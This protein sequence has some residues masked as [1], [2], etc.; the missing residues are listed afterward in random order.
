MPGEPK[1]PGPRE[2]AELDDEV[3]VKFR[4]GEYGRVLVTGLTDLVKQYAPPGKHEHILGF[5][6]WAP[7]D[8][9]ERF[10]VHALEYAADQ[11]RPKTRKVAKTRRKA[12]ARAR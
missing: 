11:T 10:L 8:H 9:L 1:P 2:F 7:P 4:P 5:L 6:T 3:V 12:A